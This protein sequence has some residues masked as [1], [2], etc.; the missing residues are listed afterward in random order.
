[1]YIYNQLHIILKSPISVL[2][3]GEATIHLFADT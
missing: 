3:I 2:E 1:M